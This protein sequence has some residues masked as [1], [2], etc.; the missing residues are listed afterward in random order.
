[1]WSLQHVFPALIKKYNHEEEFRSMN[2]ES[3]IKKI[4]NRTLRLSHNSLFAIHESRG[5]T[6]VELLASIIVLVAIGSVIAGI[7]SSSLRGTNKTNTLENIR[8]NGNYAL[9]Q[10]SKDIEYAQVF[11]GLSTDGDIYV[12]SCPFSVAPTPTPVTTPYTFIKVTPLNSDAVVYSCASSTINANDTPLVDMDLIKLTSCEITC[13]QAK[14]TD[15]PIIGISFTLESN[16]R[17][18]GLAENSTPPI[19]FSTSITIRNYQR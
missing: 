19:T 9:N 17:T 18:G 6:L 3:R 14:S 1:M 15:V 13:T 8:Q 4:K 16:K 5:F 2:Q 10:I 12:T 7:I 11:G